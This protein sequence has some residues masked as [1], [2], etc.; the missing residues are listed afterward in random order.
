MCCAIWY[1]LYYIKNLK[2]WR[3]VTSNTPWV[4]FRLLK[5][6]NWYKICVKHL[7]YP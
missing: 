5:F 4:F 2:K 3:S 7:I 1:H 6:Y